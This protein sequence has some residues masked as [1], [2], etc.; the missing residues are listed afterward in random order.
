[1]YRDNSETLLGQTNIT[2]V[3]NTNFP[4]SELA[5]SKTVISEVLQLEHTLYLGTH[6]QRD[7][8]RVFKAAHAT[9]ST[10]RNQTMS[11]PHTCVR[12]RVCVCARARVCIPCE[13]PLL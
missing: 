10:K 3:T 7:D 2:H 12:T 9:F 11:L 13:K 6:V 4:T 1:M 5:A 8:S